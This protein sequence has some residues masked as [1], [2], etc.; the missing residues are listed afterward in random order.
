[1]KILREYSWTLHEIEGR[2]TNNST[3]YRGITLVNG[4]KTRQPMY[5]FYGSHRD[6]VVRLDE[7]ARA[8]LVFSPAVTERRHADHLYL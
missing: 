5:R 4:V 7:Y 6:R 2:A 1:M 3:L 8:R